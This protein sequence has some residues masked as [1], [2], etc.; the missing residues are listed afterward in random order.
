MDGKIHVFTW[1]I[2]Q[3]VSPIRLEYTACTRV[4]NGDPVFT[5]SS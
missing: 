3:R 5:N 4:S 2:S 1:K